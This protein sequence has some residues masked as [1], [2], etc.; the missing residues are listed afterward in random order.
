MKRV[1]ITPYLLEFRNLGEW[2]KAFELH[3]KNKR[4]KLK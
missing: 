3:Y 1:L 2:K 4:H